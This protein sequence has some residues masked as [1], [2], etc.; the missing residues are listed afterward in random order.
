MRAERRCC[1]CHLLRLLLLERV[2]LA[3]HVLQLRD[4]LV[5]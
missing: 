5:K 1:C 2:E 4:D 3:G